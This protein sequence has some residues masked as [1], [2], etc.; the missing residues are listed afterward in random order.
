MRHCL[1][2]ANQTLTTETLSE[3]V[4]QRMAAEPHEF[5][6]V[7]PATPLHDQTD[8]PEAFAGLGPSTTDRA[9]ALACQRLE[10]ALE[11]LRGLGA[12]VDGE[13]GDADA[14]EAVRVALGHLPADE[15][16]VSTLPRG[17]SQWLR[18]DL[19]ARLRKVTDVPVT[20]LVTDRHTVRT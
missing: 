11:H 1:I 19:P 12:T 16:I 2:V 3:A 10:H 20:H 9:Y 18:R 15:I 5:H 8:G 13:V 4:Q 17:L 14:L 7:A 6:V